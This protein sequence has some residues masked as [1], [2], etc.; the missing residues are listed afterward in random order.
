MDVE[1]GRDRT[2][3]F[4][5]LATPRVTPPRLRV[6]DLF[7]FLS[8]RS[9][10]RGHELREVE[11]PGETRRQAGFAVQIR[12]VQI[13][14]GQIRAVQ[15]R[16]GQIRAVQIRA[17]QIRA[18]QIR[19]DQIR[20]V[21]DTRRPDSRRPDSRRPDSRRPDTRRPDSRGPDTRRPDSRRPDS[22][23][24]DSRRPDS[25]GLRRLRRGA[26]LRAIA[27][28]LRFARVT[29][30]CSPNSQPQ[31]FYSLASPFAKS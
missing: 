18:G 30:F 21:A 16:A 17:G 19:A 7:E 14:A 1:R 26:K 6:R 22:R 8:A 9:E 15:I 25:R 27:V 4:P 20:A 3:E 5:A 10:K 13:R 23:R 28:F 12:A 24:P 31:Q 2:G 29:E 11:F